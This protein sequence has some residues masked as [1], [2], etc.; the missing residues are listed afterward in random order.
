MP[1]AHEYLQRAAVHDSLH[2]RPQLFGLPQDAFLLLAL[3][4]A[5]MGIA[6]RL[7]PIVLG[8]CAFVYLVLLPILRRLFEKEPHL[9]DIVPRAIRYNTYY[10]CQ[11]KEQ[12]SMWVDR[13]ERRPT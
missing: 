7:D 6:S 1:P 11:A 5:C 8:A 12:H 10:P 9:M 2:R 4:M 3:L 13:V